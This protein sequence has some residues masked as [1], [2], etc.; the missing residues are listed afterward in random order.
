MNDASERGRQNNVLP[1]AEP[2]P[3]SVVIMATVM[4]VWHSTGSSLSDF[5]M[6]SIQDE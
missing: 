2:P 4:Q 3:V 1:K 5:Q 6:V